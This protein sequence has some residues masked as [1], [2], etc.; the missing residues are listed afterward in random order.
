MVFAG[1]ECCA[2]CTERSCENVQAAGISTPIATHLKASTYGR[3]PFLSNPAARDRGPSSSL[4]Y[5]TL[6]VIAI[7]TE[8]RVFYL[9]DW[10]VRFALVMP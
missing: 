3:A 1:Q 9:A 5:A 10:R 7:R 6:R 8:V 2:L 4:P